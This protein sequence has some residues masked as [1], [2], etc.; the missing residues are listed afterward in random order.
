MLGTDEIYIFH[1]S[2]QATLQRDSALTVLL[3]H[4]YNLRRSQ[5]N[6]LPQ[7]PPTSKKSLGDRVRF[8]MTGVQCLLRL[9]VNQFELRTGGKRGGGGGAYHG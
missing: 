9:L 8:L 3:L 1:R 4:S 5:G 7:T 6:E 2:V